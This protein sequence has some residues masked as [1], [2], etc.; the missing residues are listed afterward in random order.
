[1]IETVAKQPV[2][3]AAPCP[4]C[5]GNARHLTHWQFSGLGDSVFNYTG[6]FFACADCGLAYIHN[7]DDATLSR[8]YAEECSYY[9]KPHFDV[10][11]PANARKY[12]AYRDFIMS[13]GLADVRIADIG[14][15]RGG[16]LT[17][18]KKDGWLA[19]CCGVDIDVRSIPHGESDLRFERGQALDLPFADGSQSLLTYFHVAEHI[20]DIDK[21]LAEAF[22]T[23]EGG[24]HV[25]I[26]V[27]D[28]E[29][30]GSVAI[31]S[32]F[33]IS[34]REHI[35]HFSACALERALQRHGFSVIETSQRI[36]PTPEFDYP[37]LM[38]LARKQACK[39]PVGSRP[40][41]NIA[42]FV[43]ESQRALQRQV[44]HVNTLLER[45]SK[46][47]FWGCSAELLSVL[48]LVRAENAIIC[49]A[50]KE[51]QKSRYQHLPILD[52]E[53]VSPEGVLVIAPYLQGDAIERAALR[54]GWRPEA[55]VRLN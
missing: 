49:D 9:D 47:T 34:I 52:P 22:R 4:A 23:L 42:A 32:A 2:A 55:I 26:E 50:S 15:G 41:G 44:A 54:I 5:R 33:W 48:P 31:G 13:R 21:V 25:L 29:N 39:A 27:P 45:N 10:T 35:Y 20:R 8:F 1:M 53:D 19:E 3:A 46:V 30:Y 11:S 14:C 7:I 37:S 38:V 28:A 51:K 40:R 6:D 17:W 18:L 24:G 43:L 12:A 36:L 16:F